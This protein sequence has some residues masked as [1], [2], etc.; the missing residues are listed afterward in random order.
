M[1]SNQPLRILMLTAV[2]AFV[3]SACG[4]PEAQQGQAP[5][6]PKV[7]VAQVLHER[8]T[9]WDEFTGRLQAL[10]NANDLI[11]SK[12]LQ[13]APIRAV[14]ENALRP[15]LQ[16]EERFSLSGDDLDLPAKHALSMALAM[17]ELATNATKYGAL[18]GTRGRIDIRWQVD[19][20]AVNADEAFEF[21]WQESGGPPVEAPTMEGFGSKLISRVL[22]ADFGGHV[23]VDFHPAGLVC[24]MKAP[25]PQQLG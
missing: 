16:S 23:S 2:A 7:D 18:A 15:H 8:V 6:A 3:L 17:H 5:G 1:K 21:V 4:E 24:T 10:A 25:L 20:E 12:T 9:E 13:D 14:I 11:T 22:A 19:R